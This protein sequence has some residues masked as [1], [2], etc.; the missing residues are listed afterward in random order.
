MQS[1]I[2]YTGNEPG[3]TR[4]ILFKI[5]VH[6]SPNIFVL[7]TPGVLSPYTTDA[8]V[9]LKLAACQTVADA[10]ISPEYVA[11]YLLWRFVRLFGTRTRL[12][13]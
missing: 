1:H 11:D 9:A 8:H 13:A 2:I 10:S 12:R 7:D 6:T 5:R 3:V 4:H